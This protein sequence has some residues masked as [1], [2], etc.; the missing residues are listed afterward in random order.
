LKKQLRNGLDLAARFDGDSF[1]L[2]LTGLP[3]AK[4]Q[5]IAQNLET[6]VLVAVKATDNLAV[7]VTIQ[8]GVVE[9]AASKTEVAIEQ[10]VE[11]LVASVQQKCV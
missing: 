3:L 10:D 2:I 5:Q 8:S 6:A 4:A 1:L 7:A 11:R 9:Y